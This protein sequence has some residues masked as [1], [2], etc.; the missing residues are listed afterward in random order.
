M[1]HSGAHHFGLSQGISLIF[2]QRARP[3]LLCPVHMTSL[4]ASNRPARKAAEV[5]SN[6][7]EHILTGVKEAFAVPALHLGVVRRESPEPGFRAVEKRRLPARRLVLAEVHLGVHRFIAPFMVLIKH[8]LEPSV[9]YLELLRH[10][11][12]ST[13]ELRSR[14]FL[15][16]ESVAQLKTDTRRCQ[17]RANP[18]AHPSKAS[19]RTASNELPEL[20]LVPVEPADGRPPPSFDEPLTSAS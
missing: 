4:R 2:R 5:T 1:K 7:H 10:F 16:N 13:L 9:K 3:D 8:L 17:P 14:A 18:G 6:F 20:L 15:E 11:K 19:G 12:D